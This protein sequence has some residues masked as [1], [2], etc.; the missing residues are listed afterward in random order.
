M[1]ISGDGAAGMKLSHNMVFSCLHP[2]LAASMLAVVALLDERPGS[3]TAQAS[4]EIAAAFARSRAEELVELRRTWRPRRH[5]SILLAWLASWLRSQERPTATP[6]PALARGELGLTWIGHAS[7]VLAWPGLKIVTDP[8]LAG[9]M[10]L[11]RRRVAAVVAPAELADVDVILISSAE[12][13]HLHFETL[14]RLPRSA[15]VV[16]PPGCGRFVSPL[17]FARLVELAPWATLPCPGGGELVA[18][19]AR[20]P[21]PVGTPAAGYLVRAAGPTVLFAGVGG[22]GPHW[23]EIGQKYAPD[24]ALLPIGGNGARG[25]ERT[26]MGPVDALHAFE[27]LGARVLVPIRHGTFV[28]GYERLGEPARLMAELARMRQ[29]DEHVMLLAQGAGETFSLSE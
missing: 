29:L 23:L 15:T 10:G 5:F 6:W 18:L 27:D 20:H 13:D 7:C 25:L 3:R 11:S 26:N 17:G 1:T 21:G 24:V 12:P 19:P 14:R 9:R 8:L 4:A 2:R 28:R 16:V 22:Y